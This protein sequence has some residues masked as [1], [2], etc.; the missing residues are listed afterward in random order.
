LQFFN[1]DDDDDFDDTPKCT[2]FLIYEKIYFY[3]Q[4]ILCIIEVHLSI[5][6]FAT[7]DEGKMQNGNGK[8]NETDEYKNCVSKE[9]RLWLR[10][11]TR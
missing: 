8:M 6:T 7:R 3:Q 4:L 1:N 9:N 5:Y 10:R 11:A 2:K